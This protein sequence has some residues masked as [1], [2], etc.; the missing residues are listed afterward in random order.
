MGLFLF[1]T[2]EKGNDEEKKLYISD[3]VD[4]LNT[5]AG[6]LYF[7]NRSDGKYIRNQRFSFYLFSGFWW[8]WS[9]YFHDRITSYWLL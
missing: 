9:L 6:W 3:M 2:W 7:Y 8:F 4:W 1:E 5:Y